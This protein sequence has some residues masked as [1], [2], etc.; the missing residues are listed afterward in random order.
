MNPTFWGCFWWVV[1]SRKWFL[2]EFLQLLGFCVGQLPVSEAQ[3][4]FIPYFEA[5]CTSRCASAY[6][7]LSRA[8]LIGMC[9]FLELNLSPNLL[10][11]NLLQICTGKALFFFSLTSHWSGINFF[12][13]FQTFSCHL[14]QQA[15][16]SP[17]LP[18]APFCHFIVLIA[19][20]Y[21]VVYNY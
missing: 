8:W 7:N 13:L 4:L 5:E 14:G 16:H 18:S 2:R 21:V 10:S 17:T 15:I 1:G 20:I 12:I 19:A 9:I 3:G 11:E 6:W